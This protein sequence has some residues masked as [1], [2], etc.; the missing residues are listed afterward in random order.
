MELRLRLRRSISDLDCGAALRIDLRHAHRQQTN[1]RDY[2]KEKETGTSFIALL[3]R[4][5]QQ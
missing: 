1:K 2:K 4:A 5:E 3:K